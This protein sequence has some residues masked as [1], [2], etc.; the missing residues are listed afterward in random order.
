[1]KKALKIIGIILGIIAITVL[2]ACSMWFISEFAHSQT[3]TTSVTT[4]EQPHLYWKTID[5][6]ITDYDYRHWYASAHHYQ[7]KITVYS[8]EYDLTRTFSLTGNDAAQM[9][10]YEKGDTI[11]AELYSWKIDSTGEITKREINSL[12]P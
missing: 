8:E 12:E 7:A 10:N 3:D 6:I 11:K 1:M 9:E 5:V 4:Q 2:S